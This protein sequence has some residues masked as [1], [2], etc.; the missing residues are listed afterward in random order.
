MLY[1]VVER[2]IHGPE[3]VYA[4]FRERGRCMPAGVEYLDSWIDEAGG[5]C[6]QLMQSSSRELLSEWMAAWSDLV[7]FEVAEV[8]SSADMQRSAY[9]RLSKLAGADPEAQEVPRRR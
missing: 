5:R 3:P 2:F 8:V 7:E 6:F 4:R 9:E 1:M